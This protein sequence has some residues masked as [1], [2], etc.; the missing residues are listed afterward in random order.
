MIVAA[1]CGFLV[2]R[3]IT[4]DLFPIKN[5]INLVFGSLVFLTLLT[6]RFTLAIKEKADFVNNLLLVFIV[7]FTTLMYLQRSTVDSLWGLTISLFVVQEARLLF[8]LIHDN[9]STS[10]LTKWLI[11]LSTLYLATLLIFKL[12]E[13]I[14]YTIGIYSFGLLSLAVLI[15]T[16]MRQKT[17]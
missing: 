10:I 2:Y 13:P 14:L 16:L 11:L 12:G 4:G 17:T 7:G 3:V 1:L 8:S 15:S 5:M 9:K 6:Y